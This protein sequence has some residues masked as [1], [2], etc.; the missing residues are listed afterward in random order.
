MPQRIHETAVLPAIDA[1]A[2]KSGRLL[3]EIISPGWGSSGHYSAKVLENAVAEK[4]WAKGTHVYLDHP[5]ESETYSRPART[6]K[7]LV[8]KL[9]EDAHLDEQGRVV[10]QMQVFKPYRPL[11]T[12]PDFAEAV[13]MSIRAAAEARMGE[14]EGRKGQI[15]TR[16]IPDRLNSVDV[17]THAGRGGRILAVLESLRTPTDSEAD[18]T[19]A[20]VSDQREALSNAL[21]AAY[22]GE[23][24]Y[25]G[26][27]DFDPE[28][29]RVWFWYE[30]PAGSGT[31]QVDYTADES[32]SITLTGDPIEVR[33]K[34]VYVPIATQ[35]TEAASTNV[36]APAG[37]HHPP[38]E[39]KEDTMPE[40]EA[41]RLAQLEEAAGRVPT[42][43]SER[44]QAVSRA[45][46]AEA[47][48]RNHRNVDAA[49]GIL[50]EA[51]AASTTPVTFS[52]LEQ[53]GILAALPTTDAGDL[54]AAAFRSAVET[55]VNAKAKQSGAGRVSGF[56]A[57][58]GTG[59]KEIPTWDSIDSIYGA[60]KGA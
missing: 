56:G 39:S 7:D 25:V 55:E 8:A 53:R 16:L 49:R 3:I 26:I 24:S 22:G 47:A 13:G 18:A 52:A 17:V 10:A 29:G 43:A 59:G 1:E 51:A 14:A 34:T 36:P 46:A 32:G 60:K 21:N 41:G 2:A 9:T 40:I 48:L 38:T 31:Y 4:V 11:L 5:T 23:K 57:T 20:A 35:P 12:D 6:V 44:D 54:D 33:A 37:Q 45:E 15:V 30:N 58:E 50:A 28:A 42:L 27:R 19:E